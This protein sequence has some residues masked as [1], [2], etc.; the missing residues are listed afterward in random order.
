MYHI[1]L[2]NHQ[3]PGLI[4]KPESTQLR[5][6]AKINSIKKPGLVYKPGLKIYIPFYL[7]KKLIIYRRK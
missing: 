6:G 2:N 5:P 1:S 4:Y 3:R 7:R